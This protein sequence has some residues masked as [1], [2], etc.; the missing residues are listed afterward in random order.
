MTRSPTQKLVAVQDALTA[1][2]ARRALFPAPLFMDPAW[3]V[4]LELYAAA[5]Q[6]QEC[7]MEAFSTARLGVK[8]LLDILDKLSAEGLIATVQEAPQAKFHLT[9]S[10]LSR[11]E[12]F[13]SSPIDLSRC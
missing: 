2:S 5:L 3:D 8:P 4:L 13:F 10:G 6:E 7:S 11:M 12:C 1:R 9:D